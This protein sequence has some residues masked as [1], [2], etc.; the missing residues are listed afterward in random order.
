MRKRRRKKK[1]RNK[2]EEL[3]RGHPM[4]YRERQRDKKRH[5]VMV[6]LKSKS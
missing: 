6:Q 5:Q 3:K 1:R 2:G 4:F